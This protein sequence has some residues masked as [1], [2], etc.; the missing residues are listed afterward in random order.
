L[1]E[2]SSQCHVPEKTHTTHQTVGLGLKERKRWKAGE[3]V[4]M[5]SIIIFTVHQVLHRVSIGK[6]MRWVGHVA[7]TRKKR[8]EYKVLVRKPKTERPL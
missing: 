2:T 1:R 7:C 3:N 5:R 4:I 6:R 8:D